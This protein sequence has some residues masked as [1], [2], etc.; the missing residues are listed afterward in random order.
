[1]ESIVSKLTVYFEDPFWVGVYERLQ[2]GS[3]E[4]CKITFGA[5][6]K[7]AEVYRFLLGYWDTLS[8]SPPIHAEMP[9]E[10]PANPKRTQREISRALRQS[11]A[12]TRAQQALAL[13]R[14]RNKLRRVHYSREQKEAEAEKRFDL[15]RQK[16]KQKHRGR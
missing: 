4:A 10:K 9:A 11:G 7:D 12:G 2:N 15:R 16:K 13:E 3:H 6:P 5:E 14:E 8:F 1:M